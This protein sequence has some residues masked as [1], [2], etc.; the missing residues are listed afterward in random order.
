MGKRA[1]AAFL[2]PVPAESFTHP[3]R[4]EQD[5]ITIGRDIANHIRLAHGAVSRTHA[6]IS[7][8]GQ[9]YVLTDLESRNGTFVNRKQVE[10]ATLRS[11][12]MIHFGNRAFRFRLD[13]RAPTP[14]GPQGAASPGRVSFTDDDINPTDL[15]A[16]GAD[17]A[18]HTFLHLSE[19]KPEDRSEHAGLAHQRLYLLYRLGEQVRSGGAPEDILDRGLDLL[20]EALPSAE[21]AVALLRADGTT[22]PLEVRS[23]RFRSE[24]RVD[25]SI[26]ISRTVLDWVTT[27]R[28][29]LVSRDT[30][31]DE[32]LKSS[33]S[34][35]V[36]DLKSLICVP[37]MSGRQVIGAVHLDTRNFLNPLTAFDMEFVAAVAN[38]MAVWM[39]NHRLQENLI[40]NERMAAIGMTVTN[41]AHNLKN[42]LHMSMNA[43]GLMDQ[44]LA[45]MEDER[46]H[47][48]W[49]L[50]RRSLE[51]M[52]RLAADMLEFARAESSEPGWTNVND[53]LYDNRE[54]FEKSLHKAGIAL[55]W[56]LD[57]DLPEWVLDGEQLQR[58]MLNLLVNAEDALKGEEDGR[59]GISTFVDD[60]GRLNIRV[61]D[62][63]CGIPESEQD[64]VFQ[65][66]YTSKGSDGSGL[67]LP[68]VQKFVKSANGR[69]E[70]ESQP[71]EGTSFRL[72]FPQPEE[73][74]EAAA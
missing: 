10:R 16:R 22:G 19:I 66:F 73:R 7:R 48:R 65:M 58:A 4:L 34:I 15:V 27:E 64:K 56:E 44:R 21:H 23:V 8:A 45:D 55:E 43:V 9:E 31:E 42:L 67:G 30:L 51:R 38:E 12:D 24:E 70:M 11:G 72:V 17:D 20:F 13:R 29:A 46:I 63:G 39:E 5:E 59:V 26:P 61:A 57:P 3:V 49:H 68:M 25:D 69:I 1:P 41:V 60:R 50:V 33:D 36:H 18:A 32:R 6:R 40:R 53:V 54:L 14:L 37:M 28:V 52:N 35:R 47:T 2:V 62:N 71:G 74:E